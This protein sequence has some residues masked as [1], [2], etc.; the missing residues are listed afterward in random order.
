VLGWDHHEYVSALRQVNAAWPSSAVSSMA[1]MLFHSIDNH[2]NEASFGSAKAFLF[3]DGHPQSEVL[4]GDYGRAMK[5]A[6]KAGRLDKVIVV[7]LLEHRFLL[8]VF[9][10]KN[11]GVRLVD[12]HPIL[13]VTEYRPGSNTACSVYTQRWLD[14]YEAVFGG[15][16]ASY[17]WVQ[18]PY[19]MDIPEGNC[20]P[21]A[22]LTV[23]HE[24][25]GR[26]M[27][28]EVEGGRFLPA[29]RGAVVDEFV[30]KFRELYVT[31]MLV[32]RAPRSVAPRS[33]ERLPWA[34]VN[35]VLAHPGPAGEW[36]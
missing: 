14:K 35:P 26:A 18:Q 23:Y 29:F 6:K 33:E 17:T 31:G 30:A 27:V 7:T 13:Q 3:S 15:N 2:E 12:G 36:V 4:Q 19:V 8:I 1:W 10:I 25:T 9:D 21:I 24:L 32:R 34:Y 28:G 22:I 11:K 16:A 5:R 20:G